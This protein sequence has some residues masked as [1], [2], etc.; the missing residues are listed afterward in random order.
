MVFN[1]PMSQTTDKQRK[2]FIRFL[3]RTIIV[4]CAIIVIGAIVAVYLFTDN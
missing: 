2:K 4:I 3:Y 1:L